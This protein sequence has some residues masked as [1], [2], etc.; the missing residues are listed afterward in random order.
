MD[1]I[2]LHLVV[3]WITIISILLGSV[4]TMKRWPDQ[5]GHQPWSFGFWRHWM[6]IFLLP[7]LQSPGS[8]LIPPPT[9]Y[10]QL[11]LESWM[12][13]VCLFVCFVFSGAWFFMWYWE[14]LSSNLLTFS[15]SKFNSVQVV[16][17]EIARKVVYKDL[18]MNLI[19][20]LCACTCI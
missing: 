4:V 12:F 2:V 3:T 10:F 11:L 1:I 6:S 13:F 14:I 15:N 16:C 20:H 17:F 18:S 7:A 8:T 9:L 19:L 5:A